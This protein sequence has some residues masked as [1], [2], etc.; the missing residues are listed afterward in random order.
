M[1]SSRGEA[2]NQLTKAKEFIEK[3]E[4][5]LMDLKRFYVLEIEN[6]HGVI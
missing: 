6:L 5:V 4:Q 2:A 3:V 1:E